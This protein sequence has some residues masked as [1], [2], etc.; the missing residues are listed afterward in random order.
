[1][2]KIMKVI[3]SLLAVVLLFMSPSPTYAMSQ[4][5]TIAHQALKKQIIADKRKYCNWVRPKIKYVYADIDGDHVSELITEP[6]YGYLTQAIYDYQNG[7]VKNV[8]SVG[9]GSFT[10]YYPKHKVLYVKNS[11]HMGVLCDYYYKYVNGTYKLV[12]CA[13]KDYGNRSYDE[14][15]EQIIYT[16]KGQEVT[17]AEYSAY[18]KKIIKNESG[19]SFSKLK[20]KRY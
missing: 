14:K 20:W 13:E 17:K 15:P 6:G 10:K 2:K 9:Q 7:K 19:K 5:N 4:Q 11:G 18:T 8:A 12:A 16:V 1:M 3:A